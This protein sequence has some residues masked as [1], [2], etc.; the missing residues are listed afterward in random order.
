M[1]NSLNQAGIKVHLFGKY[2]DGHPDDHGFISFDEMI[3]VFNSSKINLNFANPFHVDTMPQIKGR[4]FE[5][6]QCGGFQITT[7]ADDIESYFVPNREIV[8]VDSMLDMVNK[9]RYFIENDREREII[10]MAGYKRM[11]KD[12]TWKNRFVDILKELEKDA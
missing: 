5:I 8:I 12:H 3:K 9:I 6:P 11:L 10:A 7:H 1:I 2:W 4:H